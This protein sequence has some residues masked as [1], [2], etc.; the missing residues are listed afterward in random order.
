MLHAE[1][2]KVLRDE[3]VFSPIA[4]QAAIQDAQLQIEAREEYLA[5]LESKLC[6]AEQLRREIEIKQ[7]KYCG[8]KRAFE[9][10][11]LDEKKQLLS[12]MIHRVEIS[13]NYEMNIKLAPG[14]EQF[15]DGLIELR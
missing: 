3:S 11:T 6:N 2:V 13:R 5:E 12:I 1:I 15:I 9:T 7:L 8:L 4:L 14:F 10:G